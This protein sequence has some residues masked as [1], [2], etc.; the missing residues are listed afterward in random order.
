MMKH[1]MKPALAAGLAVAALTAPAVSNPAMA[2]AATRIGIVNLPA[3]VANSTAYQTA[4][5]QRQTTYAAQIQQAETRRQQLQTQIQPLLTAFNNAR[6]SGGDQAALQQQ[7]AQ[8]QQLQQ[9]G[10]A[11]LQ[12]IL[13]PVALSTAYV[14]EQIQDQL[15][16]A[17][18]AAATGAG[19]QVI[20]SPDTVLYADNSLT[21]N[22]AVLDQL[23][24]LIPSAQLVP[25]QGWLPREIREQQAAAQQQA[26]AQPQQPAASGR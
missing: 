15:Q 17:V 25:P 23:N 24:R 18:N 13:A 22:Q 10:Q 3:V 14:E 2:Q 4:Q 8:L 16:A 7:A 21:L 26:G 19:V 11:E 5:T 9:T 1:L 6:Q 20:L 12:Q